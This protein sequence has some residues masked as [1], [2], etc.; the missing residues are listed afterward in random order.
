MIVVWML[1]RLF[2]QR[3]IDGARL[4][5]FL[6]SRTGGRSIRRRTTIIFTRKR[7]CCDD[8]G[9]IP[10]EELFFS[11]HKPMVSKDVNS[12]CVWVVK[13]YCTQSSNLP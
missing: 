8:V 7:P 1:R 6:S 12:L 2:Q 11:L 3:W 9:Y 10:G 4:Y 5:V 13:P